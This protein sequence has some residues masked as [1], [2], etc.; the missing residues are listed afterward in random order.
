MKTNI[1]AFAAIAAIVLGIGTTTLAADKNVTAANHEVSTV[2]STVNK[3][4]K[5]EVR[6]NVVLYVS[7]SDT[8]Q[9]KVY[10]RYYE[11]SALVQNKNGV[12]NIA[13]YADQKLVVWV[14]AS[15]L[16]SITAYDN[17]EVR[18]FGT[19]A[20]IDMTVTLNDNA[21]AKLNMEGYGVSIIVNDRAKADLAGNVN[22]CSLK[23][24]HSAT[25]KGTEFTADHITK[26]VDGIVSV[27]KATGD[28][29]GL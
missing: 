4:S 17:A 21:Y 27:K 9:V 19:L 15:D 23:Y 28:F 11:Q 12:L 22:V 1:F 24:D 26:T 2:L 3:V 16:R 7:D 5:I 8:D 14:K 10:N 6:G 20:P 18:S 13:S 25:V 29:A